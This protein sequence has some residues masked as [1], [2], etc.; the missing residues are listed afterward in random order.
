MDPP[1]ALLDNGTS[2]VEDW[3]GR[4]GFSSTNAGGQGGRLIVHFVPRFVPRCI[5][6]TLELELLAS[7]FFWV[8][9]L[10]CAVLL[11][12]PAF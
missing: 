12:L 11:W 9:C 3:S 5:A 1:K 4:A 7:I 8:L 10:C 2:T 6:L